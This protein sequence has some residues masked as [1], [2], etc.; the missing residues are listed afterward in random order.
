VVGT[1]YTPVQNKDAFAF[2]DEVV[3]NGQ[4]KY[5]TAGSLRKGKKIWIQAEVGKSFHIAGSDDEVKKY[6]L[7]HNSHDGSSTLNMLLTPVRT[8]CQNTLSMAIR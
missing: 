4:A 1:K 6:V 5:T 8:V 2:F 7:L 3:G